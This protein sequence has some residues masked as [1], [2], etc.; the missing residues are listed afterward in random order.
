M[1]TKQGMGGGRK[2]FLLSI[3]SAAASFAAAALGSSVIHTTT[4]YP[5]AFAN[6]NPKPSSLLHR[7]GFTSTTT[8]T[9][10]LGLA[11]VAAAARPTSSFFLSRCDLTTTRRHMTADS[12]IAPPPALKTKVLTLLFVRRTNPTTGAKE[13]LLGMKKRGFGIG[14]W[15]GFGGKV[16][17]G[18]TIEAAA[19]RELEEESCV[20]ASGVELRGKITFTFL[21]IPEV[22]KV[23]VFEAVGPMVGEP[24]ET[25][26]MMPRWYAESEIPFEKMWADDKYWVPLFLEG[27][28]FRALFEF[29]DE[30]TILRY[31][32]D[33]VKD[34]EEL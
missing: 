18:E 23:S 32:L 29:D 28:R 8:T 4:S 10:R 15:N 5:S 2:A 16:E 30:S 9:S 13:V 6:P 21:T 19:L 7:C 31:D 17:P 33:T 3:L 20:K 14:K 25:E 27:K 34:G 12:S 11:F 22:L 24:Q 1:H 26:E